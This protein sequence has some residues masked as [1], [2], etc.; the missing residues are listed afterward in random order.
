MVSEKELGMLGEREI[1]VCSV[2]EKAL[3][4]AS[5]GTRTTRDSMPFTSI[6]PHS[7]SNLIACAQKPAS[8]STFLTTT[9]AVTSSRHRLLYTVLLSV[10]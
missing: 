6:L 4:G 7:T 8:I 5:E 10:L 2:R 9:L 3:V 1:W